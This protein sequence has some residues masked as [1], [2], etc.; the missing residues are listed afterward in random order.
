MSPRLFIPLACL[1]A[2]TANTPQVAPTPAAAPATPPPA[3]TPSPTPPVATPP[4]ETPPATPPVE[5]PPP[6]TPTAT[7]PLNL[8]DIAG[9][10][11]GYEH[12]DWLV[13]I[14]ELPKGVDVTAMNR[15]LDALEPGGEYVFKRP[16][17]PALPA[18][19]A[20]GDPWTLITRDGAEPRTASGY[21]ASVSEASSTLHF[22]FRLG[23][24]AAKAEAGSHALALRGHHSRP[25]KLQ[26]PPAEA[27]PAGLLGRVVKELTPHFESELRDALP[28]IKF[29]AG[30]LKL[31]PGRFP[32][33]RSHVG[34]L[35]ALPGDDEDRPAAS[36]V[37]FTYPDGRVEFFAVAGV[38]G[39]VEL[40]G[41]V[42]LD[43]D[44]VD[45]VA[46]DDSYHEGW[47]IELLHWTD[48]RPVHHTLTGDGL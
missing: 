3:E 40:L 21:A 18:G 43:G 23:P 13:D 25:L 46:Y 42:D 36:G 39:V 28:A 2:C 31:Y 27:L 29:K 9:A 8:G 5:T 6:A 26:V 12:R 41:I 33:G 24:A 22:T 48:G 15:R 11:I 14:V 44:G 45:E 47:Y 19:Y 16:R 4:V 7:V 38:L 10:V 17:D 1:V 35:A 30:D 20:I 37:V 34:F 32:G